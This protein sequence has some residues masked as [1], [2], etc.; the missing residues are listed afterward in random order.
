MA[1]AT[2]AMPLS[3][4]KI[5]VCGTKITGN[6]TFSAG[7]GTVSYNDNT[8]TL[9]I[10][11]V[12]YTKTGSSNNGIS[13]DEVSGALTI[14]MTGTVYFDIGNADAVLCK[15]GKTTYINI[16]GTATFLTRSNGHAALKLQDGSVYVSGSGSL[17][18][19]HTSS[20]SGD[21]DSHAAKGGTGN[22]TLS[23]AIKQ[24]ILESPKARLYK[25]NKV[26]INPSGYTDSDEFST[27]VTFKKN[28][29]TVHASNIS[30]FSPGN[31]IKIFKPLDYYGSSIN[32]LTY[33]SL[34]SYDV[35]VSDITPVA[36]INSTNFPDAN[37]RN[38]L[39]ELF[40]KGYINTSDVNSTTSMSLRSKSISS[41][42]GIG[43]FTKLTTLDCST[44]NLTSLDVSNLTVLKNLYCMQNK[45]TSLLTPRSLE[46]LNVGNNSMT[47]FQ[48]TGD[49]NLKTLY[50]DAC[51][52][53]KTVKLINNSA[54]ETLDV[55]MCN[56]LTTFVCYGGKLTSLDLEGCSALTEMDCH[57]NLITS[58]SNLPSSLQT[59]NCSSNKF[60]TLTLTG[61]S[62]LKTLD[63]S[64]NT[65]LTKLECYNNALTSLNV[66]S[67]PV[68]TTL[69]CSNNKLTSLYS[70]PSS[71]QSLNCSN[72]QLT[73]LATI[74]SN[75]RSLYCSNNKFS[76]AFNTS[77]RSSLNSLDISNNPNI[78]SLN[79]SFDNLTNINVAYCSGI[80]SMN[81]N[82]N[83]LTSL[84]LT[85]C[86]ALTNLECNNNELTSLIN[87]PNT[88]A[89]LDCS[90][91]QFT[92]LNVSNLSNLTELICSNNK[93]TSLDVS[94]KTKLTQLQADRNQLTSIN[95]QGC[96]ALELLFCNE[97]KLSSL[98]VQG[99]NALRNLHCYANQIKESEANTLVNSLCTIPDGSEGN[100]N[101]VVYSGYPNPYVDYNEGN[102][103]NDKQVLTARNKRW[104]VRRYQDVTWVDIPVSIPGDVNGDGKVNVSDVSALINMILGVTPMD[105]AAGDVNGDGR[106]NVSDVSALINI[107]LGV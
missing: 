66:S 41:L 65:S 94:Y 24:C 34:S 75:I 91:N 90:K 1:I 31:G 26:I 85:G 73:S 20:G 67:C 35:V 3:A 92:S 61:K 83:K 32:A 56:Q 49:T 62:A 44:N 106:V 68:M 107:I 54:L 9:N 8:R 96:S 79:C 51:N 23:L 81:C 27:Q 21:D 40:P 78:T 102:I 33:S 86:S 48:M 10:N 60:T 82:Y 47:N 15:S 104:H 53:L 37:F 95:V 105:L 13:V 30:S 93:L 72:N 4:T 39:L 80:T 19:K 43:Y 88:L 69:N 42:T 76:G 97:N 14:N 46:T 6:T 5:Y 87:M 98:S 59:I 28:N 89:K 50:L 52:N 99:C 101:Y 12:S 84:S 36:V 25:L 38:Y 7:G 64:N 70:L 100:L 77:Y 17:T 58:F 11:N 71:L 103:I 45:L 74:P 22:E 63:V 57:S 29:N 55:R 18:L 2:V 16:N